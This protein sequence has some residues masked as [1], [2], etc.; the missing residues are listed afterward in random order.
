MN[1]RAKDSLVLLQ[2]GKSCVPFQPDPAAPSTTVP[3]DAPAARVAE[4]GKDKGTRPTVHARPA[5]DLAR[6]AA[7]HKSL[8]LIR[9]GAVPT[10]TRPGREC[11]GWPT[12]LPRC[13]DKMPS[14]AETAASRFTRA[15]ARNCSGPS[16][17]AR[18][19]RGA[20]AFTR[21]A[22]VPAASPAL[23]PRMHSAGGSARHATLNYRRITIRETRGKVGCSAQR[24]LEKSCSNRA[25]SRA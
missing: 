16:P 1:T 14:K 11:P 21:P 13:R 12:M 19:G 10:G 8:L 4:Q 9:G 15:C 23:L 18:D 22:S 5:R 20:Q 7:H 6:P 2:T 25:S 17:T 24:T 3:E